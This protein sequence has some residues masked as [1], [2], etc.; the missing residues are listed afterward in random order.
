MG[1]GL[2]RRGD[3]LWMY[4]RGTDGAHGQKRGT[5]RQTGIGRVRIRL[6]GFVSQDTGPRGGELVTVP[7]RAAGN[8]LQVN[9]DAAAGGV[10]RV[11]L[12]DADGTPIRGHAQEDADPLWGNQPAG[13][14]S[15]QGRTDLTPLQGRALRLRFTGRRVKVYAFQFI[16]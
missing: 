13:T 11:E 2:V 12:L 10:L 9:V 8:A 14:V 4:Y 1:V 3:E 6:D 5:P 15:W 7:I 16:D